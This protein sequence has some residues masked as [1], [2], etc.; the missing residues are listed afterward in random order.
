M[1]NMLQAA[2]AVLLAS[3][4]A[5]IW[6]G[7][8]R[9]DHPMALVGAMFG[10]ADPTYAIAGW[11]LGLGVLAFLIGIALLIGGLVQGGRGTPKKPDNVNLEM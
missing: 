2:I 7:E 10:A 11:A 5:M 8:Y 9:A 3:G 4:A 6:G 1:N